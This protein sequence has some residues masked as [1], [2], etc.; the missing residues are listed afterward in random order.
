MQN[1][2]VII[3]CIFT[4]LFCIITIIYVS[5]T[6]IRLKK[7]TEIVENNNKISQERNDEQDKKI[8]LLSQ[9]VDI[10]TN[11]CINGDFYGREE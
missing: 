6:E 4:L 11:I 5:T 2:G 8:R 9:D 10:C 1:R 7:L 3:T